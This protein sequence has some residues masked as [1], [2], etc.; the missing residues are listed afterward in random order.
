MISYLH[1]CGAYLVG[2]HMQSNP[3]RYLPSSVSFLNILVS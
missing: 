2:L 3:L 1:V